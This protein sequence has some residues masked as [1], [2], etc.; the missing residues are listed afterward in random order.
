MPLRVRQSQGVADYVSALPGAHRLLPGHWGG[1]LRSTGIPQQ[2]GQKKSRTLV[3]RRLK[4]ETGQESLETPTPPKIF[5]HNQAYSSSPSSEYSAKTFPRHIQA[6]E[7][8][9]FGR[10]WSVVLQ[11]TAWARATRRTTPCSAALERMV[12]IRTLPSS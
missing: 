8:A 10:C 11:A 1:L 9:G 4:C 5:E 2:T 12:S 7:E 6:T 3:R